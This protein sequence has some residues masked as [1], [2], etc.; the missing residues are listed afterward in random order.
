MLPVHG[1][2]NLNGVK[3]ALGA[4]DVQGATGDDL[5]DA[6][7]SMVFLCG[8]WPAGDKI[9]G[10]KGIIIAPWAQCREH[11]AG[12][13][14]F[15]MVTGKL[16]LNMVVCFS[17]IYAINMYFQSYGAVS[18]IKVKAYWFHVRERVCSA[19]F[20]DPDLLWR[21]FR[22]RLGAGDCRYGEGKPA[23]PNQLAA[24]LIQRVFAL[25]TKP[26]MR[27]G[28]YSSFRRCCCR[29]GVAGWVANQGHAGESGFCAVRHP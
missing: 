10:K 19:P 14:T 18:I 26:V 27:P 20:R 5:C 21:L 2:Y 4:L 17:V 3:N 13:L 24:R 6:R 9:G 12:V 1:R 16:K 22:V 7:R 28:R 15:L 25:E 11:R 29:L 8:E 23:R